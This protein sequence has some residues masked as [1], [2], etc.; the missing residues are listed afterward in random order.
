MFVNR[1][2]MNS[3]ITDSILNEEPQE[4]LIITSCDST[5]ATP[6]PILSAHLHLLQLWSV[7]DSW[8]FLPYNIC[9]PGACFGFVGIGLGTGAASKGG[10]GSV[11]NSQPMT[12]GC[13]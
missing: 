1:S 9:H 6:A 7:P 11:L 12:D 2:V 5:V 10:V 4:K 13:S 3:G 8:N